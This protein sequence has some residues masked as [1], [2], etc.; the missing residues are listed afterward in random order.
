MNAA[1]IISFTLCTPALLF[2][3]STYLYRTSPRFRAWTDA[4]L[5]DQPH[6]IAEACEA[7][8][9]SRR[10]RDIE[11]KAARERCERQV[12]RLEARAGR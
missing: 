11:I 12:A 5:A 8:E 4:Q 7:I 3:L 10:T 2:V 6:K 1:V 9:R